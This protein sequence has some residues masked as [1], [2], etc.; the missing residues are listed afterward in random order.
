MPGR[1]FEHSP[2]PYRPT[3][4]VMGVNISVSSIYESLSLITAGTCRF[5]PGGSL[6]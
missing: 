6:Y 4:V 2:R 1:T 3:I 5:R